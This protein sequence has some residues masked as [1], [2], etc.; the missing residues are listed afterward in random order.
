MGSNIPGVFM[1]WNDYDDLVET[2]LT[3]K[4][5][6]KRGLRNVHDF[7]NESSLPDYKCVYYQADMEFARYYWEIFHSFS[8]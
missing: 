3:S 7:L 8:D 4:K 2:M 5:L 1:K 6:Q